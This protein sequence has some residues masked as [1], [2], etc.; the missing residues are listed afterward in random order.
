[1]HHSVMNNISIK[2]NIACIT[3]CIL[4]YLYIGNAFASLRRQIIFSGGF[5][6]YSFFD[7][8]NNRI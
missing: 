6:I 8:V 1:M 5:K 7:I 3:F 2:N 4:K